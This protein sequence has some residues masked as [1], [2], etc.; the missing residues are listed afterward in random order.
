MAT[1]KH[2]VRKK[3]TRTHHDGPHWGVTSVAGYQRDGGD[4][5]WY[6]VYGKTRRREEVGRGASMEPSI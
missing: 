5:T 4:T 2:A 3:K 1:S 6:L